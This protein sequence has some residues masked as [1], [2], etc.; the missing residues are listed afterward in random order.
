[1]LMPQTGSVTWAMMRLLGWI[2]PVAGVLFKDRSAP[3]SLRVTSGFGGDRRRRFTR[4]TPRAEA[5]LRA[6]AGRGLPSAAGRRGMLF[7]VE[8]HVRVWTGCAD[9][10]GAWVV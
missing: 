7:A 4:R 6:P 5:I 10:R 3:A 1:M 8:R 9:A 2:G